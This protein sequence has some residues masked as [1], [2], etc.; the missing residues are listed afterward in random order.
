MSASTLRPKPTLLNNETLNRCRSLCGRSCA[1]DCSPPSQLR[2][3]QIIQ[4]RPRAIA[5]LLS[6]LVSPSVGLCCN[7]GVGPYDSWTA[8]D[9][10]L[11]TTSLTSTANPQL[12]NLYLETPAP[13]PPRGRS[14]AHPPSSY[15]KI[16]PEDDDHRLLPPSNTNLDANH[17]VGLKLQ[18]LPPR[19]DMLP[20]TGGRPRRQ[21][22]PYV[23][24]GL[25][26]TIE[27]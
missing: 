23:V 17:V 21:P 9:R 19:D 1:I 13:P 20:N 6:P 5:L 4:Y 18:A 27:S 10:D 26:K 8:I 7:T 11:S 14:P 24:P 22:K 2:S 3:T 12:P 15:Q 16:G 25:S